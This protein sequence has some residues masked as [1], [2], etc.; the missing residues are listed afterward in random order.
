MCRPWACRFQWTL[1][2]IQLASCNWSR[3]LSVAQCARR[4]FPHCGFWSRSWFSLWHGRMGSVEPLAGS[5]GSSS[6][7]H[8]VLNSSVASGSSPNGVTLIWKGTGCCTSNKPSSLSVDSPSGASSGATSVYVKPWHWSLQCLFRFEGRNMLKPANLSVS[9][10]EKAKGRR[11]RI[12]TPILAKHCRTT[13]QRTRSDTP[14]HK[15]QKDSQ[16]RNVVI[17]KCQTTS[18]A[19]S[20]EQN[21]RQ[22]CQSD[23]HQKSIWGG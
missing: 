7:S 2:F 10:P 22:T 11:R 15:R 1:A 23:H 14:K 17:I 13:T 20:R 4:S 19:P 5:G 16:N 6:P 3:N 12:T 9:V 8:Q 18:S 21:Q